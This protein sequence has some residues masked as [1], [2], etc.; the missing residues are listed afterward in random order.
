MTTQQ[1][2]DTDVASERA[3]NVVTMFAIGLTVD[4]TLLITTEFH[5]QH[6]QHANEPDPVNAAVSAARATAGRTVIYSGLTVGA[7]LGRLLFFREP[8]LRSLGLDGIGATLTAVTVADTLAIC[9]QHHH[10]RPH[11]T[12]HQHRAVSP[13]SPRPRHHRP[14]HTRTTSPNIDRP[15]QTPW[16]SPWFVEAS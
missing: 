16:R 1:K 6:S 9:R 14:H 12:P 13:R 3:V 4:Y 2:R 10:R 11:P 15:L 8:V 7:A 5:R